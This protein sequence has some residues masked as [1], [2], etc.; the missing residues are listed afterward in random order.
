[1]KVL[2]ILPTL[3]FGGLERMQVTLANKLAANGYDV[4]VM[5]LSPVDNLRD[6]LDSRVRFIYK[7]PKRHLGNNIPYIRHRYYD[8]GMWETRASARQLYQYYV[9][10]EE[11]YDVEIAFFRGMPVKIISGSAN[12]R[13]V[14]LAWVHSDFTKALGYRN[15]FQSPDAVF[16]AYKSMN[17]VVCV[18]K[19]AQRGFCAAIG[20]TGNLQTIYNMIPADEIRRKAEEAPAVNVKK[21]A[22]HLVLVGRCTDNIKGQTRL[23]GAVSRLH[24]EG[25]DVSLCLVGD[26]ADFDLIK[27]T[28]SDR[29]AT[30][31]ITL[32]G[33]QKNPYPYVKEAD[34]LVCAS[35]YE[36]Y[37]LT[38]A[39]ALLLGVPALSTDCTGPNEILD[40]GKYGMIVDNSEEGLYNGIKTFAEQPELL[41]EYQKKAMRRQN[42]FDEDKIFKQIT[43][44]FKG[45]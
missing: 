38:V 3:A 35:Y 23:I 8:D 12:R 27:Q 14:H 42:F 21:A 17:R 13:A 25:K 26:G 45:D 22:L 44:L 36:G 11:A 41:K 2:F 33:E 39:E 29:Q 19:Q 28:V 30:A 15:N 24:D 32:T 7:P 10:G 43:A 18:S 16:E 6:E 31:Y 5:I 4:T 20:D 9:G 1:M 34:L 40:R 37:N